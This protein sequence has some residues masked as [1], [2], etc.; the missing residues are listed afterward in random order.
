MIDHH[1][2]A[3]P[4]PSVTIPGVKTLQDAI[5]QWL[6]GDERQGLFVP[7][8]DWDKGLYTGSHKASIGMIYG[9]RRR[10]GERFV[11]YVDSGCSCGDMLMIFQIGGGQVPQ[12][13]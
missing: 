7:L 11:M 6:Y 2:P 1:P 5:N 8:K 13:I 9:K 4:A 3:D 12:K 10:L